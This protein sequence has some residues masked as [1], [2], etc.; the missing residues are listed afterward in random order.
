M[1]TYDYECEKC[2]K[3]E[4]FQSMKDEPVKTCPK[5]GGNVHRLIGTGG[6]IIFKGPGFYQTDYKNKQKGGGSSKDKKS[7]PCGGSDSCRGCPKR[8]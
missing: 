2:G 6:G 7:P 4:L 5:C 3:F 8:D 1:P